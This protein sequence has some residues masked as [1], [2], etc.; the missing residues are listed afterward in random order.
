M[1]GSPALAVTAILL[2]SF[3]GLAV[4][5]GILQVF[6]RDWMARM[7]KSGEPADQ[8][9][10]VRMVRNG[11]VSAVCA[12]ALVLFGLIFIV[13]FIVDSTPFAGIIGGTRGAWILGLVILAIAIAFA[14]VA[15]RT[16]VV[17]RRRAVR[18]LDEPGPVSLPMWM[19]SAGLVLFGLLAVVALVSGAATGWLVG[20]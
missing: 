2:Y 8:A 10:R 1:I 20:K 17:V 7:A 11:L 15:V 5:G 19:R 9:T 4:V 6:D 12:V 16:F 13:P 14:V 3:A 18:G